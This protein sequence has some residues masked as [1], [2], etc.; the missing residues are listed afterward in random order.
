VGPNPARVVPT[1]VGSFS[2]AT[3]LVLSLFPLTFILTLRRPAIEKVLVSCLMAVGLTA[4]AASIMRVV[5]LLK[6]VNDR[7]GMFVGFTINTLAATE[8]LIGSI[9]ACLPCLKST[10]QGLL[11]RCGVDF[12]SA[13]EDLPSFVR[14]GDG[15]GGR[16]GSFGE[17]R[18][19][20]GKK[21]SESEASG[22][23]AATATDTERVF[24]GT[25]DSLE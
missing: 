25:R 17:V 20:D 6:W 24:E 12:S 23:S 22:R 21:W 13:D 3:D 8:M 2:I 7:D 19:E 10:V 1:F 4:S 15:R 9:A 16:R 11:I 5:V 14:G 18:M